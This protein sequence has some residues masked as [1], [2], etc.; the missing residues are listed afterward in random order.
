M[1]QE[2]FKIGD[3]TAKCKTEYHSPSDAQATC[4]VT[5]GGD[6]RA[7][8]DFEVFRG[9]VEKA[10]AIMDR[11]IFE[12]LEPDDEQS[13]KEIAD[14]KDFMDANKLDRVTLTVLENEAKI[15]KAKKV[16]S[17]VADKI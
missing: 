1:E 13:K 10:D 5:K 14:I 15:Q 4:D 17:G 16:W 2:E 11:K 3:Y 9:K 12:E 7:K 6:F 8:F